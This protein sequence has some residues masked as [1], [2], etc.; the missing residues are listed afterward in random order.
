MFTSSVQTLL[1]QQPRT[2]EVSFK[3]LYQ[4]CAGSVCPIP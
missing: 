1:H 3:L 4:L 2:L